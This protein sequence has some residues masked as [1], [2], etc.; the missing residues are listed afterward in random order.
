MEESRKIVKKYQFLKCY[1]CGDQKKG[2]MTICQYKDKDTSR[3]DDFAKDG[4]SACCPKESC[5]KSI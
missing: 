1:Q 3:N 5:Q 4:Y 2:Q